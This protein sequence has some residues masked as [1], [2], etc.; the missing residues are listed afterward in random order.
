MMAELTSKGRAAIPT[1][2]FAGPDRSY[3]IEDR[4]HAINAKA[5]ARQ[6]LNAGRLSAATYHTI[7]ARANRKLGKTAADG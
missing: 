2:K 6:Q 7:L 4:A 3:P 1:S 5:R